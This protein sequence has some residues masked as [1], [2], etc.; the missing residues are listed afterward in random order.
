[1]DRS[2]FYCYFRALRLVCLTEPYSQLWT[3]HAPD[4]QVF[5]WSSR[6]KGSNLEGPVEGPLS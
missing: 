6:D 3:R 5:H 1:M 2:M 4:L